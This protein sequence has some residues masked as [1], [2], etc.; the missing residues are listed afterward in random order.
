MVNK[1]Q[2]NALQVEQRGQE[3]EEKKKKKRAGKRERYGDRVRWVEISL[4]EKRRDSKKTRAL[5]RLKKI[6]PHCTHNTRLTD[7]DMLYIPDHKYALLH[8]LT[9]KTTQQLTCNIPLTINRRW[10][11]TARQ[12]RWIIFLTIMIHNCF[13]HAQY[14]S[15]IW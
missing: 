15:C 14:Y 10:Q 9:Y 13:Q 2:S 1:R 12:S 11:L 5:I 6:L 7:T 3:K 4:N 8:T